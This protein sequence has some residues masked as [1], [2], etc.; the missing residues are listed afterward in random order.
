[1][2]IEPATEEG[3]SV[4][5]DQTN[6]KKRVTKKKEV[7]MST[8]EKTKERKTESRQKIISQVQ[9]RSGVS[10]SKAELMIEIKSK[11]GKNYFSKY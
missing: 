3:E 8:V 10:K 1:M 5:D 4:R 7:W 6:A 2:F 11:P 9:S